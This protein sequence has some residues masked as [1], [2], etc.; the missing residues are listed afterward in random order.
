MKVR[1]RL[2]STIFHDMKVGTER[3]FERQMSAISVQMISLDFSRVMKPFQQGRLHRG[4][5]EGQL[6][7]TTL[8]M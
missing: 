8:V 6:P 7:L 2:D 5:L 4:G 3:Y 1:L